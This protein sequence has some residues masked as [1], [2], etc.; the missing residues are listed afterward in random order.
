MGGAGIDPAGISP[1]GVGVPVTNYPLVGPRYSESTIGTVSSASIDPLS[2]DFVFD[3]NGTEE[4]MGDTEQ[5]VYLCVRTMAGSR[6]GFQTFGL[7]KPMSARSDGQNEVYEVVRQAM[8][9]VLDDGSVELLS[10]EIEVDRTIVYALVVWKDLKKAS[11]A[12]QTTRVR[13]G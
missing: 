12:P 5:R 7:N 11:S 3:D 13:I 10:V 8:A 2:R 4:A 1:G 6:I 9:P